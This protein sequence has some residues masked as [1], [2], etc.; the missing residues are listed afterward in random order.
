MNDISKKVSIDETQCFDADGFAGQVYVDN[1][2]NVG[3]NALLVTVNGRHPKKK[4][5]DTVRNYY[6]IEGKGTFILDGISHKV[7]PGD[8]FI[9]GAGHEY[10]YSGN[11]K[12]FEFN[13]SPD[14]SFRDE[15]LE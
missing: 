12:L 1:K 15:I 4:M 6:V 13:I 7:K 5:I 11:M 8:L 2:Q 9:V 10:E 3:F 14:N